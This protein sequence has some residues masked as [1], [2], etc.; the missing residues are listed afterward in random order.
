MFDHYTTCNNR[1]KSLVH[2]IMRV[3]STSTYV[4]R[5]E[6]TMIKRTSL[7]SFCISV[8]SLE[9]WKFAKQKLY[10]RYSRRTC[11]QKVLFFS[12]GDPF[13]PLS[14]YIDIDVMMSLYNELGFPPLI[15]LYCKLPKNWTVGEPGNKVVYILPPSMVWQFLTQTNNIT[16][17]CQA[18]HYSSLV[19]HLTVMLLSTILNTV[20]PHYNG[21]LWDSGHWLLYRGDLLT[22]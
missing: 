18:Y 8:K 9:F 12:V 6:G 16:A 21:H 1:G 15:F 7:Q 11:V 5:E 19:L 17:F 4:D 10:H 20:K 3:M 13:S 14:T 22:G 2:L